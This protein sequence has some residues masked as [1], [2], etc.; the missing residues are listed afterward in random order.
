MAKASDLNSSLVLFVDDLR[1]VVGEGAAN[2]AGGEV[3]PRKLRRG[4]DRGVEASKLLEGSG[5][6]LLDAADLP[7]Q[8]SDGIG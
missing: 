3:T 5:E 6:A 2:Y 4:G 7:L 1:P 8:R